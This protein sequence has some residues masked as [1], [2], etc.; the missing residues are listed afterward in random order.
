MKNC[1]MLGS[2]DSIETFG[3][4]DGPGIRTV[5]FFNGCNLRC[6]FCHNP[7]TWQIGKLNYT[8][9]EIVEKV[10]RNKPYFKNGGGVTFSGGEPLIQYNFL[11]E[12]CKKLKEE[13]IHIAIDTAGIGH[14]DCSELFKYI[15]LV[16][17]D[18]KGINKENYLDITQKDLF[19]EYLEFIKILYKSNID[20]WIRQVIIP[21]VNDNI[22]YINNLALFIKENI[23][24]V[25]RVDFLP[26]HK[27]GHKKYEKLNIK[28]PYENKKE[29]NKDK[30]QRL[31]EEFKKLY[32][33]K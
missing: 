26:Y 17:L 3:L 22:E 18:I 9:D 5:I 10:V 11:L 4:V 23:K 8:V 7:E 29:M 20:I 1:N 14:K 19:N 27:L 24:N 12:A 32:E 21:D 31:Y 6:K 33:N 28:D 16:L 2:I 13:G 30:C 15:D 25:K